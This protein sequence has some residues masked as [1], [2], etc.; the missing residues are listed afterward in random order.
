[1]SEKYGVKMSQ[2]THPLSNKEA[3]L[4]NYEP[5]EMDGLV[6]YPITVA[7]YSKWQAVKPVLCLRQGTLPAVYA[8]MTYLQ[9]IWALDFNAKV[10][11]E[12]S[13]GGPWSALVCILVLSLRLSDND[14][15][16]AIG[17]DKTPNEISHIR[18]IK[19]GQQ[20]DITPM[21]FNRVRE[22]IAEQN[23]A[24]LPDEADNPDIIE[25]ANDIK[26]AN[27]VSLNYSVADMLTS[28]ASARGLRRK[29]LYDWPIKELEDE[30]RALRRR[31]GY[32]LASIAESQGAKFHG[33]NPYPTWMFDKAKDEFA[34]LISMEQLQSDHRA[35]ISTSEDHATFQEIQGAKI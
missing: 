21:G 5:I 29:D 10:G 9:C 18:I 28:V 19:D 34:G 1:M 25:A 30:M 35:S 6:Y 27:A 23:G 4:L 2:R 8:C 12:A 15:I 24:E 17:F 22:L 13:G 33:G 26:N 31:Y 11:A 16:Q 32:F 20:H 14:E 3:A 7:D